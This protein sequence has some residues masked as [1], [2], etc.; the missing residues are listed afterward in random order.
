LELVAIRNKAIKA[1]VE[2][3]FIED[4]EFQTLVGVSRAELAA[5]V[6][7]GSTKSDLSEPSLIRNIAINLLGYP[8]GK[9]TLLRSDFDLTTTE[10]ERLLNK[11]EGE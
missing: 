11:H 6:N 2:G 8:H 3:P 7:G 10:L 1:I 4:W 5:S 9:E